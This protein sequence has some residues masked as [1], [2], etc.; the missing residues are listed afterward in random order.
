[1]GLTCHRA[2]RRH[3][4]CWLMRELLAVLILA[5]LPAWAADPVPQTKAASDALTA[6]AECG[7]VRSVRSMKKE[8]KTDPESD[9]RP[10]GLVASFPLGGGKPSVG[11]SAKIGKD[12]PEFSETWEIV[13]RMD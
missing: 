1:M 6:C 7:V 2:L 9:A 4:R 11:S 3:G 8:I 10:S 5:A 12:T 13:V